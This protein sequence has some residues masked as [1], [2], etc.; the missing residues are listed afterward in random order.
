LDD[1]HKNQAAAWKLVIDRIV[2]LSGIEKAAGGLQ[3]NSIQVNISGV[4][5]IEVKEVV[6]EII[7]NES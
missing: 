3:R 7:D 6:G 1:D 5:G 4:P 2:P